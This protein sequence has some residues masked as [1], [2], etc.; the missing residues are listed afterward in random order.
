[1]AGF[2]ST[3]KLRKKCQ[4]LRLSMGFWVLTWAEQI[5]PIHRQE[6]VNQSK[7]PLLPVAE[8]SKGTRSSR[9]ETAIWHQAWVNHGISKT[10]V[11]RANALEDLTGIRDH[12][13]KQSV[14]GQ[15]TTDIY[16][17]QSPEGRS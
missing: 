16:F 10:I 7:R 2:I 4:N 6:A 15:I 14:G 8:A 5:L 11:S 9:T 1:M 12:A 13:V 17:L 3:Y